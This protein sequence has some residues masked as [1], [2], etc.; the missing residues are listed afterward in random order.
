MTTTASMSLPSCFGKT[1]I[2]RGKVAKTKLPN[3]MNG[4]LNPPTYQVTKAQKKYQEH[5]NQMNIQSINQSINCK[6]QDT[7]T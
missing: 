6:H 4:N 7:K 1:S 2:A 3:T 5:S